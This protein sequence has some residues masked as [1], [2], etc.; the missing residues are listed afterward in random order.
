MFIDRIPA[1]DTI[2]RIVSMIDPDSFNAYFLA[3]MKSVHQLTNG[4]VI[5]I[6]GNTLGGSYSR[7]DRS[8]TIH[9]IS[10]YASANK[11]VLSQLKAEQ[12]S[13]EITAIPT[14]LK[15]LDLRG[16]LVNIDAMGCNKAIAKT[17][18][19]KGGDYLLAVKNNQGDLA[20]AVNKAFSPHRSACLSDDHVNIGKS[21]GRIENLACYLLSSADLDG[22]FTHWGALKSIVMG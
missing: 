16:A 17:I 14:L 20:K 5:A 18:V 6:D 1:D 11:L 22:D 8:S 19:D 3:W 2:A 4:E 9:M 13:N 7:D 12:K 21:H 15:M 10:A